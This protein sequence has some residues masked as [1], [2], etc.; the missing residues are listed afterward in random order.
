MVSLIARPIMLNVPISA[1]AAAWPDASSL[2]SCDRTAF[3]APPFWAAAKAAAA[4]EL[5]TVVLVMLLTIST[6]LLTLSISLNHLSIWTE[7]LAFTCGDF[8]LVAGLATAPPWY[9]LGNSMA[10]LKTDATVQK[11]IRRIVENCIIDVGG[12]STK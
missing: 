2:T 3:E 10:P 9:F 8:V 5:I 11:A 1:C 6:K 7:T 12:R 4:I